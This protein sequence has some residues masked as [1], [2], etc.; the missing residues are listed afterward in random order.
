M[1]G[2]RFCRVGFDI[3]VI[4]LK[5]DNRVSANEIRISSS[6]TI[7]LKIRLFLLFQIAQANIAN[8][9]KLIKSAKGL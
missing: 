1:Q 3:R 5:S 9:N 7:T 4:S 8:I 2:V 6:F